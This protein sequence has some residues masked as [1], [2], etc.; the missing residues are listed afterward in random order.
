MVEIC[1]I[2]NPDWGFSKLI[3]TIF[4]LYFEYSNEFNKL[5]LKSWKYFY[6]GRIEKES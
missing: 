1:L 6:Q 2:A 3:E 5:L 4:N